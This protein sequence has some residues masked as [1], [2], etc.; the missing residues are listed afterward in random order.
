MRDTLKFIEKVR[1][2][3]PG[4]FGVSCD[5]LKVLCDANDG[6]PLDAASDA[7]LYGFLKG[8]RAEHKKHVKP[9]PKDYKNDA[10]CTL[11]ALLR[12][13]DRSKNDERYLNS[14]FMHSQAL[15]GTLNL[16]RQARKRLAEERCNNENV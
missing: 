4:R 1:A 5:E 12:A 9:R 15:D 7:F 14:M 2:V 10:E 16:I 6:R 13:I 8:Q 3:T 11:H